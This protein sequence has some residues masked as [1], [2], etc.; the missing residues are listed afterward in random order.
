MRMPPHQPG[1]ADARSSDL[2]QFLLDAPDAF[3]QQRHSPDE[4]LLQTFTHLPTRR[5]RLT[6]DLDD[7]VVPLFGKQDNA[8][9]ACNP[10]H[11]TRG[12]RARS[13]LAGRMRRRSPCDET[14]LGAARSSTAE[15]MLLGNGV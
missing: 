9:A 13:Q 14:V 12:G 10:R 8:V 11:S 15:A 2:R 6:F 7:T 1:S 4:R 5:S 3:G